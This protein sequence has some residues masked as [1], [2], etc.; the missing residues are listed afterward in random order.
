M[1]VLKLVIIAVFSISMLTAQINVGVITTTTEIADKHRNHTRYV[2]SAKKWKEC[3]LE[4]NCQRKWEMWKR[5]QSEGNVYVL[6]GSKGNWAEMH[7]DEP[8]NEVRYKTLLKFIAPHF[9]KV[10]Y[11]ISH[12]MPEISIA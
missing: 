5:I 2:E 12:F 10:N 9:E 6:V 11:N 1:K 3:Y 7:K 8:V 4:I